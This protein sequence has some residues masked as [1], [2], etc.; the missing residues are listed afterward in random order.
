MALNYSL[1]ADLDRMKKQI[2][3][4][5]ADTTELLSRSAYLEEARN[6]PLSDLIVSMTELKAMFVRLTEIVI[7]TDADIIRSSQAFF[8]PDEIPPMLDDGAEVKIF[9]YL[10]RLCINFVLVVNTFTVDSQIPSPV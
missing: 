3:Q 10:R 8:G 2:Q 5:P 4:P 9:I 1:L 7:Y 6:K